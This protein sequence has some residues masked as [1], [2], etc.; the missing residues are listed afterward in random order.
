VGL[1]PEL[2]SFALIA[3]PL[4]YQFILWR[5]S[6]PRLFSTLMLF[7]AVLLSAPLAS[8]EVI[9]C[10][11]ER[12]VTFYALRNMQ[13]SAKAAGIAFVDVASRHNAATFTAEL[14]K[15][16]TKS[17]PHQTGAV[18][19]AAPAEIVTTAS[20]TP[21]YSF[22]KSIVQN[23][24]KKAGYIFY[25]PVAGTYKYTATPS[26]SQKIEF[27]PTEANGAPS[28]APCC[29]D[30]GTQSGQ[31][32]LPKGVCCVIITN[33]IGVAGTLNSL[34]FTSN[35]Y[36]TWTHAN[37]PVTIAP[38]NIAVPPYLYTVYDPAPPT[39]RR[40]EV[41][42]YYPP[43]PGT[44]G[45]PY[46]GNGT[47]TPSDPPQ[48][49]MAASALPKGLIVGPPVHLYGP[50]TP[51]QQAQMDGTISLYL[52]FKEYRS[53]TVNASARTITFYLERKENYES[54][55]IRIPID[56]TVPVDGW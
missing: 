56:H 14:N 44:V 2:V 10:T 12:E 19:E 38:I 7:S 9:D 28:T 25:A 13:Y 50:P 6:M 18:G 32:T 15:A 16:I 41:T 47:V 23:D 11:S 26:P 1:S 5:L 48:S 29:C 42:I 55:Y 21:M 43:S 30:T 33:P 51:E 52:D 39:F 8:Q 22:V 36:A 49:D 37:V 3:I 45:L 46:P 4:N 34:T 40:C 20:V 17:I 53:R 54:Y 27:F 31:A 24:P 35:T